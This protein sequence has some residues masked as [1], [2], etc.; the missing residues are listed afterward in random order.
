[1]LINEIKTHAL[2][3]AQAGQWQT[4]AETIQA[5]TVTAEPRLC[6][7]VESGD[8]IEAAG[9]DPTTVLGY[10]LL[11]PNGIMLFQK[12]SSSVGV[13]WAHDRTRQWMAWFV[14]QGRISQAG[15]D[16]LIDL[17]APVTHTHADVTAED[18]QRAWIV[19]Q[20]IDPITL[21]HSVAAAKLNNAQASLGPEHTDGL[22]L[23]ELQARCD[24][25]AASET[26]EV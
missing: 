20:C 1:M 24:A 10:M 26:G 16:A 4:V 9:D 12:L 8:T 6:Y 23:Q 25:I 22:T 18:C 21:A 3:D 7:A 14:S 19:T 13:T 15:A 2:A 5:R 17:S 11:D